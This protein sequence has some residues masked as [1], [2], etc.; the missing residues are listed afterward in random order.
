MPKETISGVLLRL[1]VRRRSLSVIGSSPE[2]ADIFEYQ[3]VRQGK[4]EDRDIK[5]TLETGWNP[6]A[7]IP[8]A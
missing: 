1:S 4:D 7:E 2:F 5:T 3:F 6:L 8:E